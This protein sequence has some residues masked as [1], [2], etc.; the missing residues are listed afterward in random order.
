MKTRL[1]PILIVFLFFAFTNTF[2]QSPRFIIDSLKLRVQ[3]S[4]PSDQLAN[5]Y[6]ELSWQFAAINIDSAIY[7]G[8]IAVKK[9]G[10]SASSITFDCEIHD[11]INPETTMTSAESIQILRI[12]QEAIQNAIKYSEAD[13]VEIRIDSTGK[14]L[15]VNIH[16][17]GKGFVESEIKPGNGLYNMRKRAEELGGSLEIHSETGNGTSVLLIWPAG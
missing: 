7:Y 3:E 12:V 1:F 15:L 17:N 13:R 5:M 9:A 11:R 16:D 4:L 14:E 8:Q 6:G 10:Q 2:A